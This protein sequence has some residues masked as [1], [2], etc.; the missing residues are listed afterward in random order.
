MTAHAPGLYRGQVMHRRLRPRP[1][2]LAYRIFSLLIDL[3]TIDAD[4]A[5][6]R[7]L[8]HNRFNL[9]SIHDRDFASGIQA[10][11]KPQVERH[12]RAAGLAPDGGRILLL[13]MPRMLGFV[14]NPLSIYFCHDRTGRLIATLYEVS[15]TFGERHS[16]LLPANAAA[17][18]IVRQSSRKRFFVSPFLDLAFDYAFRLR[19]PGD[20]F[21]LAIKVSDADGPV[22]TAVHTAAREPLSDAALARAFVEFPVMTVKVVAAIYWEAVRLW[23]R[24]VPLHRKPAPPSCPVTHVPQPPAT[25][26]AQNGL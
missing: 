22:L 15:N 17:D 10:P 24:G 19:P 12:L 11:L 16:Y 14:F 13:C 8:S 5:R 23:I 2:R 18:G 7:L 3:D 26:S 9:F 6:L 21:Q 25:G 4:C 20:A 1:H